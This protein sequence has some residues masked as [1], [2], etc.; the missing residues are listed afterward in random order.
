MRECLRGVAQL[1]SGSRDLL[2]E[3]AQVIGEAE[4]VLEDV[5][6]TDE[7][8]GIIDTSAG[9]GFDEPECA[10]AKGAFAAADPWEC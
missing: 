6:C 7:V 3:H 5:D 1:L 2:R 4:H 8:L 10:H 9:E